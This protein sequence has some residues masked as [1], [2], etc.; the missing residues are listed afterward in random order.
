MCGRTDKL[1]VDHVVPLSQGGDDD[2]SNV[3]VLCHEC[4][5][6]KHHPSKPTKSRES[7]T[8]VFCDHCRMYIPLKLYGKKPHI[9]IPV[10]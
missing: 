7:F 10:V 6:K 1:E 2:S 4:H 3:Q 9:Y 8:Q 5:V